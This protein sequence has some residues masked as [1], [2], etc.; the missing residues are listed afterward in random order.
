MALQGILKRKFWF[1][2]AEIRILNID[3][4]EKGE[5]Y[6]SQRAYQAL[7]PAMD[8]PSWNEILRNKLIT[9]YFFRSHGIL[10]PNY[11]GYLN[12]KDGM[13]CAGGGLRA[14]KS[15]IIF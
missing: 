11:Y 10:Y 2:D 14:G 15:Y 3:S 4:I 1:S 8:D 6:I 13:D 7:R 5:S 12:K 9:S